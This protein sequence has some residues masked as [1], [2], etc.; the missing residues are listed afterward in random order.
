MLTE[1]AIAVVVF[2]ILLAIAVTGLFV[3][4]RNSEKLD[5]TRHGRPDVSDPQPVQRF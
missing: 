4:S 3:S 1:Q 5:T 2:L